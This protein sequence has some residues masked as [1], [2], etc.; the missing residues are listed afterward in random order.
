MKIFLSADFYKG[1]ISNTDICKKYCMQLLSG[2]NSV[3][4]LSE[5][6]NE[7]TLSHPVKYGSNVTYSNAMRSVDS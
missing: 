4:A 5:I 6:E 2:K 1:V 7:V 3:T